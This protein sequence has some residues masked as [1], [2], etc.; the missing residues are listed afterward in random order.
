MFFLYDIA[1]KNVRN[2][3]NYFFSLFY[4][5]IRI[6]YCKNGNTRLGI[7]SNYLHFSYFCPTFH[8]FFKSKYFDFS[9]ILFL[10]WK[11]SEKNSILS[12]YCPSH[13][14]EIFQKCIQE[15]LENFHTEKSNNF[16][17]SELKF[18]FWNAKKFFPCFWKYFLKFFHFSPV[19]FY[20]KKNLP[21]VSNSDLLWSFCG[22]YPC[23]LTTIA[24]NEEMTSK[25]PIV[26]GIL[27]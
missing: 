20:I 7:N 3:M 11:V 23:L 18:G 12:I 4:I 21:S 26:T 24:K 19:K 13:F 9:K 15:T 10:L 22:V 8:F 25:S 17:I 27:T 2:Q 16:L 5:K 6:S 1:K 14:W